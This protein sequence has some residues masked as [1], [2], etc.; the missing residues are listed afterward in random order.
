MISPDYKD[1]VKFPSVKINRIEGWGKKKLKIPI[2]YSPFIHTGTLEIN[3]RCYKG[4]VKM[5]EKR[6]LI[7]GMGASDIFKNKTKRRVR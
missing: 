7:Y 3:I 5:G 1:L 2:R 4:K 6:M